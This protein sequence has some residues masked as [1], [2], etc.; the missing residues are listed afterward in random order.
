MTEL[1]SGIAAILLLLTTSGPAG[2]QVAPAF[3]VASIRKELSPDVPGGIR[4]LGPGGQFHAVITVHDLVR[5]AYGAPLALLESQVVGGPGW[6]K[7][8]RF[9]ITAKIGGAPTDLSNGPPARLLAMIRSLLADRFNL[10]T[11][12][13]T[14][15]LPVYDLVVDKNGAR[16]P[17]LRVAD[18]TCVSVPTSASDTRPHCGFTRVGSGQVSAR[19]MTLEVFAGGMSTRPEVQQVVRNRTG[20]SGTFDL[21]LEYAPGLGI[22]S[23]PAADGGPTLFTAIREQLGLRLQPA[24]GSVDVVVIEAAERPTDD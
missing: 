19:G 1:N 14:R 10:R 3:E 15:R 13:E 20:L 12:M 11:R 5:I 24:V 9:D 8:D 6:L 18:G 21:D 17:R 4:P 23:E 22:S 7:I 2:A 16:G